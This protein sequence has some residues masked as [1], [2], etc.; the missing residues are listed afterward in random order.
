MRNPS[1]ATLVS[2][3]LLPIVVGCGGS[4]PPPAEPT[5]EKVAPADSAEPKAEPEADKKEEESKP[6][7]TAAPK[8]TPKDMLTAPDVVFM[9]SFNGSDAKV[10][11]EEKCS[12]KTKGDPEKQAKCMEQAR[13][14]VDADGFH[15]KQGDDG[16][17][18]WLTMRQKG[19]AIAWLHRIPI[20]FGDMTATSIII[21]TTGKDIGTKPFAKVPS[22]ITIE[23]P[24]EFEI[25]VTDPDHGKM[26]YEA[27]IG[28]LGEKEA[29]TK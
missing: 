4:Q 11:A 18:W 21:K 20:E 23:V 1:L 25:S 17:W 27:K 3:L 13:K 19:S 29:P 9:Y 22:E 7:E 2:A 28:L 16:R 12:A 24:N 14:K 5:P 10:K 6:A 8:R 15:F 26:V